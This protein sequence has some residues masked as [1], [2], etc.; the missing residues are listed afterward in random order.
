M[1]LI[2]VKFPVQ[3]SYVEDWPEI[4]REFTEATRVEPGNRFFEWSRSVD[5]PN[6]YVLV[7]GFDDDA[8]EAHVSSEH[9]Q[10]AVSPQGQMHKALAATPSIIS[11]TIDADGW[12][13]M[14][15][16]KVP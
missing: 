6:E 15:E 9:F 10:A 12:E 5:D 3:P 1:I 14:G 7:E 11:H 4:V 8:A 16:M 13:D 2:V